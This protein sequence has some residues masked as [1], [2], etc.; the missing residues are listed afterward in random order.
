MIYI[1]EPDLSVE[2]VGIFYVEGTEDLEKASN[3]LGTQLKSNIETVCVIKKVRSVNKFRI[4]NILSVKQ[5]VGYSSTE[6]YIPSDDFEQ[7]IQR[8]LPLNP[9]SNTL[10]WISDK[11][12]LASDEQLFRQFISSYS[13]FSAYKLE[14]DTDSYKPVQKSFDPVTNI[15][16][17]KFQ[18][19]KHLRTIGHLFLDD[20][21]QGKDFCFL[22]ILNQNYKDLL[23]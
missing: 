19:W 15:T 5:L 13:S 8:L 7:S 11:R 16:H 22:K 21:F 4:Y 9:L 3:S 17:I 2:S 23:L 1:S 14:L 12:S 18:S 6:A 10:I 20:L